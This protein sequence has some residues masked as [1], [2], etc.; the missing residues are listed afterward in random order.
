MEQYRVTLGAL[1]RHTNGC[2][3]LDLQ[4]VQ[5]QIRQ[6][7]AIDYHSELNEQFN[8]A[9]KLR[10]AS[11]EYLTDPDTLNLALFPRSNEIEVIYLDFSD[12]TKD[13]EPKKKRDNLQ[14]LLERVE[15]SNRFEANKVIIKHVDIRSFALD[16]IKT[17]DMVL[18]KFAKTQGL[19]TREQENPS[20][21]AKAVERVINYGRQCA[22][23]NGT[24]LEEELNAALEAN[25]LEAPI[26][27]ELR[28]QNLISEAIN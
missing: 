13:D 14:T 19:Y 12:T 2:L 4:T 23:E 16:A 25:A 5:K 11:Q 26:V 9:K 22:K 18:D 27:S 28:K 1:S 21:L 10:L 6:N 3:G 17:A 20:T 7:R 24:T 8:Y 15:A